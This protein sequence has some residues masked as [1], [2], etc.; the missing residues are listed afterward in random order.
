MAVRFGKVALAWTAGLVALLIAASLSSGEPISGGRAL[1]SLANALSL[2]LYPA[3]IAVAPALLNRPGP[4]RSLPALA[5]AATIASV[6]VVAINLVAP[7]GDLGRG[8]TT[9]SAAMVDSAASWETRNHA[10]WTI[11]A[12]F[13]SGPRALLLAGVG[14]EIG[15]WAAIGIPSRWRRP[16]YW[17]VGF[18][19]LLSAAIVWDTTYELVVLHA[20]T[21]ARVAAGYTML[22]PMALC[23]G[24]A[25]PT[26]AL[27]RGSIRPQP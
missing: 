25:L 7:N 22:V 24:L 16:L 3:G 13:L 12:A 15:L 27:L 18:G 14:V 19:L 4:W 21:D 6:V 17:A 2:A 8:V 11:L 23:A 5:A 9:L 26:L 20:A 1:Q 10:A